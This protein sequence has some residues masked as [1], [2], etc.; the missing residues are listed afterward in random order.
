MLVHSGA[1]CGVEDQCTD[2][3]LDC[4]CPAPIFDAVH[5]RITT[6]F[7][8]EQ[9]SHDWGP[10]QNREVGQMEGVVPAVAIGV[11]RVVTDFVSDRCPVYDGSDGAGSVRKSGDMYL[12]SA[13]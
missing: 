2:A 4:D 10:P 12:D 8:F 7:T 6:T 1:A 5:G 13:G 3:L 11:V 9:R